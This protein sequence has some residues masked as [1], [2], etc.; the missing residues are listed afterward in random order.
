MARPVP[1]KLSCN[2][3]SKSVL[4]LDTCK[5]V[6]LRQHDN[7]SPS[8]PSPSLPVPFSWSWNFL[9]WLAQGGRYVVQ[10]Q[11]GRLSLM[12]SWL[13]EQLFKFHA[14]SLM[15]CCKDTSKTGRR[16]GQVL[17]AK[18]V[19]AHRVAGCARVNLT[20]RKVT[21]QHSTSSMS[22]PVM[23]SEETGEPGFSG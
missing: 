3:T 17:K 14:P 7:V 22:G 11:G 12:S 16:G 18:K 19:E 23:F 9:Q 1:S 20:F 6:L 13:R 4:L 21:L 2:T 8:R 15:C 10:M 5:S